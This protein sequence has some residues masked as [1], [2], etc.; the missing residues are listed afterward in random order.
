MGMDVYG[1]NPVNEAGEYFRNNCWYWSPLAD[2]ISEMAP[3]IARHCSYWHSNDG[4]GLDAADALTLADKLQA[5]IDSGRCHAYA[6]IREAELKAMPSQLCDICGGTGKR[7]DP[8]NTG[9]GECPCNGCDSTGSTRPWETH[10]PFEV[11]N[12]QEFVT[13]LR[14]CGGFEIW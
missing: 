9:P 10:Y 12:V 5:E 13:F 6:A 3:D 11:E 8:P 2:Y 4:D 1:R 7:A 14:G